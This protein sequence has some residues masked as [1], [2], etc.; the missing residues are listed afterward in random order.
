MKIPRI[1]VP[2]LVLIILVT[3]LVPTV[4]LAASGGGTGTLTAWGT[5]KGAV[6]GNGSIT[7]SG[8]GDLWIYDAA[9]D[10]DI[11]IQG[12]GVKSEFP[13]GWI[14]YQGF[15]GRASITGSQVTVVIS[16]DHI[17]LHARGNGR[18]A[19]RGQGGYHTSGSGWTLDTT[20]IETTPGEVYDEQK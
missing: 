15:N 3:L 8:N 17:R 11:I 1:L 14:H 13:S 10:A 19:L 12:T 6:K 7:A 4:A 18:F 16:G 2:T 20:L 9:G 5:G